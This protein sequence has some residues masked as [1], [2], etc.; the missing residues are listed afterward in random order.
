MV[1][2]NN[3]YV[4]GLIL[5]TLTL[6]GASIYHLSH[7]TKLAELIKTRCPQLQDKLRMADRLG[8]DGRVYYAGRQ[9]GR[10]LD[11]VLF[12]NAY[13][14]AF[15][16]DPEFHRLLRA[17]RWSAII[18]ITSFLALVALLGNWN[19]PMDFASMR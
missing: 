4:L 12:F 10:R 17:S 3:P 1:F 11:S 6:V 18:C 9:A 13:A 5:V 8:G 7:V 19:V 16:N 15:P 2:F 14:E